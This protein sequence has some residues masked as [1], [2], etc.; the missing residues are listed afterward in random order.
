MPMC[1]QRHSLWIISHSSL[2]I[3]SQ[4]K[5]MFCKQSSLFIDFDL[6]KKKMLSRLNNVNLTH[7]FHQSTISSHFCINLLHVSSGTPT[8][9]T[10]KIMFTGDVKMLISVD[11]R[12]NFYLY[13]RQKPLGIYLHFPLLWKAIKF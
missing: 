6:E 9:Q 2:L 12:H 10:Y 4:F 3:P 1:T 11:C 13:P 8:E 5:C 7:N